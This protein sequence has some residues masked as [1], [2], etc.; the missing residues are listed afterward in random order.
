M[1]KQRK[2]VLDER[3]KILG[4]ITWLMQE[5]T[6]APRFQHEAKPSPEAWAAARAVLR[7]LRDDISASNYKEPAP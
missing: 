7:R 5:Y 2:A 6:E 3:G 4:H 1:N